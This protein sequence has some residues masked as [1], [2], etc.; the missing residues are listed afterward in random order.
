MNESDV[1]PSDRLGAGVRQ[2]E[3]TGSSD[4]ESERPTEYPGQG[5]KEK[6]TKNVRERKVAGDI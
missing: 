5:I 1:F 3:G 2:V 4:A 6:V